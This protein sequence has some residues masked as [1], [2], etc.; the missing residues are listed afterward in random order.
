[1][2]LPLFVSDLDLRKAKWPNTNA[3]LFN[4]HVPS[5]LTI[6]IAHN[7]LGSHLRGSQTVTLRRGH[8]RKYVSRCRQNIG[9]AISKSTTQSKDPGFN[10]RWNN[11]VFEF[12][13]PRFPGDSFLHV[14]RKSTS[15]RGQKTWSVTD[16]SSLQY[17]WH[18]SVWG[19]YLAYYRWTCGPSEQF[20]VCQIILMVLKL[21]IWT[22]QTSLTGVCRNDLVCIAFPRKKPHHW[23][24]LQRGF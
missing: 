19:L 11:P 17:V 15:S 4:K 6:F 9:L 21:L 8:W 12:N 10:F 18:Q 1:M 7:L 13:D 20:P 2:S 24:R 16:S 3:L 22:V 14:S 5:A 23:R